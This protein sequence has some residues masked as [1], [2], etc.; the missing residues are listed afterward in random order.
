MSERVQNYYNRVHDTAAA[1]QVASTQIELLYYKHDTT[2]NAVNRAFAFSKQWGIRSQIHPASLGKMDVIKEAGKKLNV[3]HVHPASFLGNPSV[4]A[5]VPAVPVKKMDELCTFIFRYGDER[6]KT[7]ALLCAVYHHALHDRFHKARDMFLIS[8]IQESIDKMDIKTQILYNRTLATLGLCAFR[9][10][11]IH[12]AHDCLFNLTGRVRELLAQGMSKQWYQQD[13]DPEQERVEKRRQMPYHMHINPDLLECCYL[14]SAMFLDLPALC[15]NTTNPNSQYRNFRKFFINYNRQLFTGPPENIREHV[16]GAAKALLSGDWQISLELLLKLDVWNLIPGDGAEKVKTMLL[17]KVKEDGLRV[18]MLTASS[19]Y[20][21]I[22][23]S[24]VITVFQI[25]ESVA[26]KIITKMIFNKE[27]SAAWDVTQSVL[28]LYRTDNTSLQT[29]ALQVS[30]KLALLVENNER[31]LDPLVGAYGYKDDNWQRG[32]GRKDRD[33]QQGG[34]YKKNQGGGGQWKPQAI[35]G[36]DPN[37]KPTGNKYR[38]YGSNSNN[39]ANTN[40]SNANKPN[41]SNNSNN[42]GKDKD[43]RPKTDYSNAPTPKSVNAWTK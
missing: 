23:L 12:K 18:Y 20:D 39:N 1:A 16:L 38:T 14:I 27:L 26:R 30:E 4:S 35:R 43:M 41:N 29:V 24:H 13:K 28:I 7:R 2:A 32:D 31:L 11:Y 10:G 34:G 17:N 3:A 8:H 9:L 42:T 5:N 22:A 40:N 36:K 25:Q 33:Q 21:S 37:W 19:K 6:L 15:K